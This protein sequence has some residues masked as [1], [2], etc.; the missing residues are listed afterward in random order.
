MPVT[1]I[2]IGP[3]EICARDHPVEAWIAGISAPSV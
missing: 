1:L 3:V 2:R